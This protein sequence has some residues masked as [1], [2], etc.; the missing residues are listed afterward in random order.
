MKRFILYLSILFIGLAGMASA[1]NVTVRLPDTT[2][3]VGATSLNI[4]MLV[5]NFNNIGAISLKIKYNPSVLKFNGIANTPVSGFTANA[6]TVNGVIAIGWFSSDGTTT[7]NIANGKL[8]DLVLNYTQGA[9]SLAFQ[10]TQ[11]EI[12]DINNNTKTVSYTDGLISSQMKVSLD[13]VQASPG[14]TVVVPLRALNLTNIG[15]ISLKINFDPAVLSFVG[16]TNDVVGFTKNSSSGT[17][18]LGWY[19][20]NN[21]PFNLTNGVM[22]NLVF[23]YT[24]N[25]T[26]IS[27]F[28]F[29]NQ[30]EITDINGTVLPVQ[31]I[32]G[33]VAKLVS[34]SLPNLRAPK[35]SVIT[36]PVSIKNM[37]VGS[38]SL[39]ISFD[40]TVL[41]FQ[42]VADASGGTV[43]GHASSG[44]LT[45]GY[46][47]ATPSVSSGTLFNIT[48]MYNGGTSNLNFDTTQSQITDQNGSIYSNFTYNNGSVIQDKLPKFTPVAAQT[49]A[50]VS[51]L[52][53]NVAATDSDDASL[54]YTALSLPAGATFTNQTFSWT[55]NYG[56]AGSY[57][58]QFRVVDPVGGFDTMSVPITVTHTNRKPTFVSVM[59]DTTIAENQALSFT[60]HATDPDTGTYAEV[61]KYKLINP[62]AGAAIDSLSGVFTWTPNFGQAG[63]YNI[64]A[65]VS[66][67]QL[68]DTSRTSIVIVSHT[69]RKPTFVSVMPD[70]TIAENQA[71]TFTYH[72]TD[73]DTGIY[74][75]VL[76]YKLVNAPAGAAIDSLTGVFTWT[77]NFGQAGTH[78]IV[79]VVSDGQLTDTSRTS[80]VVVTHTNRK[81]TFVSVM[82]DT[83][84]AEN[85]AFTFTYHATDPDTG[86]YAEVLKYK[87]VNAPA[88]AAIDSL[89]G[90]FTWT[91][92]FGQAGTHNI[93]AV[94]SDGQLTDTSRTSVVVVTHTNRPPV[95]TQVMPDTTIAENQ[96]FTFAYHASDPDTADTLKFALV[97]GTTGM[98]LDTKTGILSWTPTYSQAGKY[99][100]VVSVTD[101][102]SAAIK[103]TAVITVLNVD[104]PPYFITALKDTSISGTDTLIFKFSGG[105]PDGDI[106]KYGLVSPPANTVINLTTGLFRFI[107]VNKDST[108]LIIVS[109]TDGTLTVYDSVKVHTSFNDI[110]IVPGLPTEY[111]IS[112]NYPN[113][114]NPSTRID[115][116]IPK[117]SK[118]VLKVYNM[119]GQEVTTLVNEE[120]SA[121]NYKYDFNA[122]NL[123][124]G[125][126][127]YRLQAGDYSFTKKMTLL[128]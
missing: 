12:T 107:P 21:T 105:D 8:L 95:F 46:Y 123:A 109:L 31:Y 29:N 61:L 101:G 39:K 83:T 103:D 37:S 58:V 68:T 19:S 96:A 118:V 97:K 127:I 40:P 24:N 128:K 73:P 57:T 28:Q 81:P 65:V 88:G 50:E 92:N 7:I 74:A 110:K 15:S 34:I 4:P 14:D 30:T 23:V 99:T 122:I 125:I 85:Q 91:P 116:S 51:L 82:P 119:L 48:F 9:S 25:S 84:I 67:G 112:Q 18:T 43:S 33:G 45:V 72:A 89:T 64:V 5:Q 55:P 98:A 27:F 71:F 13:N 16:L 20:T 44:V 70:T 36:V 35:N 2:V 102:H 113:P 54:T 104:R 17:A 111:S 49:V 63:S 124:S 80:V 38:A 1:Q 69:N 108:W 60:Y 62:P 106:L 52:T 47:N 79:A 66:D 75:E 56:Q 121:G 120:L 87:L 11:C 94:V 100:I 114:F 115:F 76:K 78:N 42:S 59:P 53:F 90:V 10:T 41:S 3:T 77:P 32:N 126:Y 93:V 22:A 117:I 6:D 26:A 86:I